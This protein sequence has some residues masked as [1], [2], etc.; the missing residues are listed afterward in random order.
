MIKNILGLHRGTSND[1][2]RAELGLYPLTIEI[3]KRCVRFWHHLH[4]FDPD[5]TR[6]KALLANETSPESHPLNTLALQ[7]V[8]KTQLLTDYSYNPTAIIKETDK[9]L[10][11]THDESLKIHFDLQN[12][13]QEEDTD[14]H[15][16]SETRGSVGTDLQQTEDEKHFLLICPK[17]YNV[18]ETFFPRFEAL[19]P[20][21]TELSD[22]EKMPFLLGEDDNNTASLAAKHVLTI[23]NVRC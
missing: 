14:K 18:R 6:H 17:F 3:Q 22:T 5:S 12:K 20:S 9:N 8:H 7:L 13:L 15:G 16:Q 23:H 19:I 11:D 4:Q 2:C 10:E 21:F 1:A